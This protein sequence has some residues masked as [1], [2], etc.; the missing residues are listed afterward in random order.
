MIQ[1]K[2]PK[3]FWWFALI[4]I[5]YFPTSGMY[6]T[7]HSMMDKAYELDELREEFRT[8]LELQPEFIHLESTESQY[9]ASNGIYK[10]IPYYQK[11]FPE[12]SP[13]DIQSSRFIINKHVITGQWQLTE[14]YDLFWSRNIKAFPVTKENEIKALRHNRFVQSQNR[15][16]ELEE[17]ILNLET[18]VKFKTEAMQFFIN[19]QNEL[20]YSILDKFTEETNTQMRKKDQIQKEMKYELIEKETQIRYLLECQNELT[21]KLTEKENELYDIK[22]AQNQLES[23]VLQKENQLSD[24][25]KI[26]KEF[27]TKLLEHK[28]MIQDLKKQKLETITKSEEDLK[29]FEN[30]N[31]KNK[32]K[33]FKYQNL[34]EKLE[35]ENDKLKLREKLL[36]NEIEDLYVTNC[37]LKNKL[38]ETKDTLQKYQSHAKENVLKFTAESLQ[39]VQKEN[40]KETG[41]LKI[42][43]SNIEIE[44]KNYKLNETLEL[45]FEIKINIFLNY[46]DMNTKK[47]EE[48]KYF[49]LEIEFEELKIPKIEKPLTSKQ[50]KG[51][52]KKKQTK[53]T[54]K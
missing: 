34:I 37:V 30:E 3:L 16:Q 10:L 18:E 39:N 29:L 28:N 5:G 47:M 46:V 6:S 17:V 19:N 7:N 22:N 51:K 11:L 50:S 12:L 2:I 4:L 52:K 1:P 38:K 25:E 40:V 33:S 45:D 44:N 35:T 32:N 27:Q 48:E 43:N 26:G 23:K 8:I 13:T 14:I 21:S 42:L 20:L 24:F 36:D 54:I 49:D 15:I 41:K 9:K 53:F 31:Q